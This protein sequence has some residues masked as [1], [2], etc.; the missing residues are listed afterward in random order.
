MGNQGGDYTRTSHHTGNPQTLKLRIDS[1]LASEEIA[2]GPSPFLNLGDGVPRNAVQKM[3]SL[4]SKK[5][6]SQKTSNSC[7]K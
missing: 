6:I 2:V 7:I 1:L 4:K 5:V 3:G